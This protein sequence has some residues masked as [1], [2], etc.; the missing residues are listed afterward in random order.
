MAAESELEFGAEVFADSRVE[1]EPVITYDDLD[2]LDIDTENAGR[3]DILT[4]CEMISG[5]A[6]AGKTFTIRQRISDDPM[7][8]RLAASTGIASVNLDAITIHSLL[9][10]FDTNSLRDA[11]LHG[12]AQRK[13]RKVVEEGYH[14][15]VLDEISMVSSDMLDILIKIFDEVNQNLPP[16]RQPIGLILVGD[17]CQLP[18]IG[19]KNGRG[20]PATPWAF[21]AQC[22]PR[23]AENM[24]RLTKV[25]RQA[26]PKFLTAL[27]YARH[28]RGSDA[29]GV[30]AASGV[31]FH[32]SNDMEFDGTTIVSQNIEVDR[33]NQIALDRVQGRKIGLPSRR[34]GKVRSEWK[35]IPTQTVVRENAYVMLLANSS[36]GAGGFEYVN[37]DCGHVRSIQPSKRAGV[38]PSV[39]VELVRNSREVTVTPLVRGVEFMDR[40]DGVT[41]EASLSSSEDLGQYLPRTHFRSKARRYV[42]GQIE[43]Y[44]IRLAYAST[45]H[46]VQGISLD[47]AQIDF[48]SW[49]FGNPAMVYV[50]LSR[51]RTIEGLRIVGTKETVA[52]RCKIDEKVR[53]WL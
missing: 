47:R 3:H 11:F 30:L 32:S 17:F 48:R 41:I 26:D 29:V 20:R 35:N 34:W 50:S 37:G 14:N 21:E 51:A 46:K 38:P 39:I 22:W 27:N 45:C 16:N 49:S 23:F 25:W 13:L 12:S 4:P 1:V 52:A 33:F 18:A 28:G 42:T 2:S 36:D 44:P 19:E 8:A 5:S 9:G 10:F 31:T 43:Y 53:P 15:V 7:Y 6:G 40:P 24:T